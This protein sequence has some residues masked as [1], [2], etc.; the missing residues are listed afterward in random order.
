MKIQVTGGVGFVGSHLV[1]A[2]IGKHE[3]I[4][5]RGDIYKRRVEKCHL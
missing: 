2:L 1:D 5:K 4:L 3:V